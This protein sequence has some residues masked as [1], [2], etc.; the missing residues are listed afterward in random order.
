MSSTHIIKH[1][2]YIDFPTSEDTQ[3]ERGTWKK[4]WR[5]AVWY[6][7]CSLA[8]AVTAAFHE[9]DEPGKG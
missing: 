6:G 7:C 1:V 9:G 8:Q 3:R 5:R 4:G 2:T